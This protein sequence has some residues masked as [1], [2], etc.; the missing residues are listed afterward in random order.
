MDGNG[1]WARKRGLPRRLGHQAGIKAVRGIVKACG[2]LKIEYLT[3]YAF[4]RENWS[5]PGEEVGFLMRMLERFVSDELKSLMRN[6][7]R[8]KVIGDYRKFPLST[9]AAVEKAIGALR[10]NTG[11][12]LNLALN[13]G[14]RQ[15][16]VKAVKKISRDVLGGKIKVDGIDEKK[17]SSCLETS[18]IPDP[19][20]LIR[21][22][23]EKRISNFLLWQISYSEIYFTDKLWPDF[24]GNDFLEAVNDYQKRERRFGGS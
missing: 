3:L 8:L 21:T 20:L 1:R 4:S 12:N 9:R 17:F 22:S 11:L 18:G 2:E 5:R 10:S 24:D 7:V 14:S 23:G 15:E 16:I 19:D 13:Y 6:N